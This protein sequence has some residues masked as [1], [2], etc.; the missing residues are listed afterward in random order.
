MKVVAIDTVVKQMHE[1]MQN[2]A[3]VDA[4]SLVARRALVAVFLATT[5]APTPSGPIK[6]PIT[7]EG[8]VG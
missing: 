6:G 8:G 2:H 1:C 3:L 4:P 7:M 5:D